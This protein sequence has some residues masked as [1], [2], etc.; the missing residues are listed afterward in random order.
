MKSDLDTAVSVSGVHK[1][2]KI[3]HSKQ[4]SLKLQIIQKLTGRQSSSYDKYK[5]LRGIDIDIKKGE[6]IGILGR[7]GSGKSTLLKIIAEIYQPTKGSIKV[8]GKLVPFIE[9]GVGFNSNLS[10]KDNVYLNGAMLG[11][12]RKEIDEMYDSIVEFAELENFMDQT[13]KNYSSGMQVRLAFSVAIQAKSD[14]LLLDE[15]LAV[16]DAAFQKKCYD[17]F[18]S[19]KGQKKTIILVSHSMGVIRQYCDR[20][21][22]IEN[23]KVA[24][25]GS[26]DETADE[27]LKLFDNKAKAANKKEKA[28]APNRWGDGAVITEDISYKKTK[29]NLVIEATIA[30]KSDEV[31]DVKF[32]F[33][34]KDSSGNV[35]MGA[36]NLNVDGGIKIKIKPQQKKKLSFEMPN[37]LGNQTYSLSTTINSERGVTTHDSVENIKSIPNSAVGVFYPLLAPAKVEVVDVE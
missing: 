13:L 14:I 17:Y 21:V 12:S 20:A 35:I 7:N 23:G 29:N 1:H 15:V 19:L 37:I 2:F 34:I 27:Y 3:P 4:D 33:R 36:N 11:F 31:K 6:F 18:D 22:L 32:G 30:S 8:N 5:A 9:L 25:S 28:K 24:F 26:A 16:G 10:G